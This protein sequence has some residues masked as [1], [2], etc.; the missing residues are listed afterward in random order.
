MPG[1]ILDPINQSCLPNI[2]KNCLIT[3]SDGCQTCVNRMY[4]DS[5][6]SKCVAVDAN[7]KEYN[8]E[9]GTCLRCYEG[10]EPNNLQCVI[11][12]PEDPNCK[13]KGSS[14]CLECYGGYYYSSAKDK[15]TLTNQLCRESNTENGNCVSCWEG[16]EL[17]MGQCI[18]ATNNATITIT[19]ETNDTITIKASDVKCAKLDPSSQR[20]LECILGAVFDEESQLCEYPLYGFDENCEE[21]RNKVCSRCGTGFLLS[22]NRCV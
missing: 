7:C 2:D 9:N 21:Y 16:Y 22:V 10:Y 1:Y 12:K 14:G 8:K 17:Q 6:V 4:Y 19:T 3:S 13:T 18:V 11:S 15:C 20:C 5:T